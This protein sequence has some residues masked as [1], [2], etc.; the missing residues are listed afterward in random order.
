MLNRRDWLRT[1]AALLGSLMFSMPDSEAKQLEKIMAS[2]PF[3]NQAIRLGQNE[4]PYGPSPASLKA[5]AEEMAK[6][7]RYAGN[8]LDILRGALASHHQVA[9]EN[10][11]LGCGSSEILGLAIQMVAHKKG[12]LV[13]AN[14]TFRIWLNPADQFGTEVVWVPVDAEMK[15]DLNRMAD[16]VTDRT[17]F[18]YLCNPN[19]PTGTVLADS[20]LRAFIQRFAPKTLVVA[21]EAYTEYAGCPSVSD[22]I[23]SYPNLI[24]AK[25]FSKIH[26]MAG[27]RVGYAIAHKTTIERLSK[28]QPWANAGVS[29]VSAAAAL[30]GLKDIEFQKKAKTLNDEA[31]AFTT[32]VLSKHG[33]SYTPSKTNFLV[34]N[35]H[36]LPFDFAAAMAKQGILLRNWLIHDKKYAR[37]SMG[38][39]EEMS[40]FAEKLK[41]VLS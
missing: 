28:F 9:K 36:H 11:L 39:P 15:H 10:I 41:I 27:L 34:F 4:N 38:T 32:D 6:G 19:N 2:A 24:V 40:I 1:N 35:V 5:M 12:Q 31:M 20:D 33:L 29:N 37:L 8:L 7:N 23:E 22:M 30:A 21:D 26:G 14:P 13:A 18:I 17:S 25:T 3:S 16:A